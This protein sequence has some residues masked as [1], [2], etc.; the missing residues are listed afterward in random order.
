MTIEPGEVMPCVDCGH[1]NCI[2][3]VLEDEEDQNQR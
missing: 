3:D 2:C 1:V